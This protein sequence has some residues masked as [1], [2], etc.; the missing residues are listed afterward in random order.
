MTNRNLILT[1]IAAIML[2]CFTSCS[3]S[4]NL[5]DKSALK[6]LNPQAECFKEENHYYIN[7]K[8]ETSDPDSSL[9]LGFSGEISKYNFL[10]KDLLMNMNKSTICIPN[11]TANT[12]KEI[13]IQV[14]PA[15]STKTYDRYAHEKFEE[16][17]A[18]IN[19]QKKMNLR[20]E[21]CVKF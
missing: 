1:A 13:N 12:P 14:K 6:M 4:E 8:M 5:I 10:Q 20:L 21:L 9:I 2:V 17:L 19:W 3:T 16:S 18:K 11:Y 7:M 15:V